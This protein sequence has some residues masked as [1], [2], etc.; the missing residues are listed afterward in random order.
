MNPPCGPWRSGGYL[1]GS[2]PN[3]M[4]KWKNG[5]GNDKKH[6][7]GIW[8]PACHLA[9]WKRQEKDFHHINEIKEQRERKPLFLPSST[10]FQT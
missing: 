5:M 10:G 7:T 6:K 2:S 4:E 1:L 9:I 8:L 3:L